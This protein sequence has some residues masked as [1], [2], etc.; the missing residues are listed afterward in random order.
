M[1]LLHQLVNE[2]NK[3]IL[4]R[5]KPP[6]C[7]YSFFLKDT[8]ISLGQQNSEALALKV[9]GH[10]KKEVKGKIIISLSPSEFLAEMPCNKRL[11]REKKFINMNTSHTHGRYPV[12]LNNSFRWLKPAPQIPSLAKDKRKMLEGAQLWEVTRKRTIIKVKLC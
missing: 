10:L 8:K 9:L 4:Y 7:L 6:Q 12:K 1:N 2:G 11:S 3:I 5:D